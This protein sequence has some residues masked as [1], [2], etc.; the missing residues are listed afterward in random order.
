MQADLD[1]ALKLTVVLTDSLRMHVMLLQHIH[2]ACVQVVVKVVLLAA[3]QLL[4]VTTIALVTFAE[5]LAVMITQF[6][7]FK[8][9]LTNHGADLIHGIISQVVQLLAQVHVFLEHT[10]ANRGWVAT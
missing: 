8:E 1:A 6:A 7:E 9:V 3:G 2:F 10:A 4:A 5:V